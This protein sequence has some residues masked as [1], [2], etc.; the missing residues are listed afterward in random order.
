MRQMFTFRLFR[1]KYY[2]LLAS[3]LPFLIASTLSGC[4]LSDETTPVAQIING[5][6]NVGSEKIPTKNLVISMFGGGSVK[7]DSGATICDKYKCVINAQVGSTVKLIAVDSAAWTLNNWRGCTKLSGSTCEVLIEDDKTVSPTFQRNEAQKLK[8]DVI[9]VPKTDLLRLVSSDSGVYVFQTDGLT[10]AAASEGNILLSNEGNG[11]A[12]RIVKKVSLAGGNTIFETTPVSLEEIF[13]NASVILSGQST[14]LRVASVTPLL[15]E[16]SLVSSEIS[17]K[18]T[19]FG[20]TLTYDYDKNK[21]TPNDQIE[22]SGTV[23][24][25]I[26]P[27]FALDVNFFGLEEF[28][29][30]FFTTTDLKGRLKVGGKLPASFET[31]D[32]PIPLASINFAPIT[33]GFIV[34]VPKAYIYVNAKGDIGVEFTADWPLTAKIDAGFHYKKGMGVDWIGDAS[35]TSLGLLPDLSLKAKAEVKV[36]FGMQTDI[37]IYNIA[38]PTGKF[39]GFLKTEFSASTNG[40]FSIKPE[41][42]VTAKIGGKAKI[43]GKEIGELETTVFEKTWP[44]IPPI[45]TQLCED[46]ENPTA[47]TSLQVSTVSASRLSLNWSGATDDKGIVNYEVYRSGNLIGSTAANIFFDGSLGPNSE[48]CYHVRSLDAKGNRSIPSKTTCG[49]T[50]SAADTTAPSGISGLNGSAL[51]TTSL[52]LNWL[53]PPEKD[54]VGYIVREAVSETP[55]LITSLTEDKVFKLKPGTKYCFTVAAVDAAGNASKPSNS[56]CLSTLAATLTAKNVKIKCSDRSTYVVDTSLDLD[57][58]NDGQIS[59]VGNATDYTGTAMAYQMTGPYS[60]ITG[61]FSGQINWTFTGSTSL[62]TDGF[63]ASLTKADTGDLTMSKV[64]D[65]GGCTAAIRFLSKTAP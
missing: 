59:V 55:Y 60:A 65:N 28:K 61:I 27:D 51:S 26:E 33:I 31:K 5:E 43:L 49:F 52:S 38:G 6:S 3:L 64:K 8:S 29:A 12:G 7:D 57:Q 44:L 14:Q 54:V 9:L 20:I 53:A 35:T 10:I 58:Q 32:I 56:Y 45:N 48:A 34:L 63:S 24:I 36:A 2:G 39:E 40:C 19:E 50:L 25:S 41:K 62:R 11:F 30:A 42:G 4:G 23:N 18:G 16:K 46:S 15:A 47:P 37:L 21:D 22:F 1:K 17:K 13:L